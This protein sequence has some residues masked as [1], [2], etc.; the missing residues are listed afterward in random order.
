MHWIDESE[1]LQQLQSGTCQ[2]LMVPRTRLRTIG[3]RAFGV[4]AAHVT[5]VEQSAARCHFSQPTPVFQK[6]TANFSFPELFSLA[7]ALF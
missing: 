7:L 6:T 2:R 3:D 5:R 4:A 1:G